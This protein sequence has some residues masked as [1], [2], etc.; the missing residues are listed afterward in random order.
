MKPIVLI[1]GYSAESQQTDHNSITAIYGNLPQDLR[2]SY[3]V[4]D[5]DLSRYVSLND[6]VSINDIARGLNRVLV[7]QH[8]E[9]LQSGFHVIIH[10]T[11]ALVIRAW[12]MLFSP[13]PSPVCNL[14]YLAGA[15]FGSGW[16]SIGQGQIA[17][18]GRYVFEHGAQRGVKVLQ[19]LELGS[20]PT[21]D[22]HLHFIQPGTRM[23][24]D[25][26]VQEFVVV[27][28]QADPAWFEF[29]VRYGHEDGSDGTVRVSGS[30]LNFNYLKIGPKA[31]AVRLKWV[32][33][34]SA[35]ASANRKSPFP[36]YY[37]L[38]HYSLPFADRK[39]IPFV[40]PYQ[41]AHTGDKMGIVSGTLTREQV[42]RLIRAALEVPERSVEE[43]SAMVDVFHKETTNTYNN[44]RTLQRPGMFTFLADPRNQYDGHAQVIVRL[45]D[46]DG[47]P[48]PV[49]NS[50]IF[51]VSDQHDPRAI[52]I[53]SLIEDTSVSGVS[54]NDITF[55]LRL[56]R[57]DKGA[58]DWVYQ[59]GKVANFAFEI[60]AIEPATPNQNPMV[61][62]LPLIMPLDKDRLMRFIQPNRTTIVDVEL[63]RLPSPDIYEVI[64]Y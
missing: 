50:D 7:E 10:S 58:N 55:Y 62:Y 23:L 17:R 26:Q 36:A 49:A 34:E 45:H 56:N 22:M 64:R 54:P 27:G 16:A 8:P 28:T 24:E 12:I 11:G 18:W 6:S 21:I 48:I 52:P 59:L 53:Q 42:Q 15:N 47:T 39:E 63:L 32:D 3:Q 25:Y 41:C 33:V 51:F 43:W 57:F 46:Q 14:I 37:E 5:I 38:K 13:K 4:V 30:N 31:D 60:T 44:A 40:I 61:V 9:L 29:P 1:H 35:V 20:G 2:Q 19:A